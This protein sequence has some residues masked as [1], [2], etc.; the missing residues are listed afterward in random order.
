METLFTQH[1]EVNGVQ[2]FSSPEFENIRVT[3]TPDNPLFC[4]ADICRI[5]EL[6]PGRVKMRLDDGVTSSNTI[7]DVLG[8][9]QNATFVNEDGLYDVILD[10]R[11]PSAR[12]FRKWVTS[13]VLPTIRKNGAY[14]TPQTI[15]DILANP[16]NAIKLLTT[17]KEERERNRQLQS[18]IR[19]LPTRHHTQTRY[20]SPPIHI[21]LPKWQ[22]MWGISQQYR[23][24]RN[25]LTFI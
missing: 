14:A 5:L 10:S 13:E 1:H 2:V 21:H 23:S 18:K 6:Q 22:R 15:D 7:T 19:Y 12:K 3:G 17:L 24:R 20:C 8:R 9:T 16:D 4:L 11:K 25:L